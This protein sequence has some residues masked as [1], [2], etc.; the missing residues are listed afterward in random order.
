MM[1]P[2]AAF[3]LENAPY[4][5]FALAWAVHFCTALSYKRA[6]RL[7]RRQTEARTSDE[8]SREAVSV[9]ITAHDQADALRRNLPLILEQEYDRFEVIVVND[10][11][12]DDTEEVLKA[13]ELK[14]AGLRHT[15]APPGTRHA[16]RKRLSLTIGIKAAHYE[17]LLLTGPDCRP[18]SPR[19][20]ATMAGHFRDG[21]QIVLGYAN[22]APDKRLLSRKATFFNLFH[23]MQY[24]PWAAR[25]KAYR[26]NPANVACR[27][28][29]F[30][31]HKGFADDGG[32]VCGETELLVNRLSKAGNTVTSLHPDGKV[33]QDNVES[34]RQWRLGRAS[35][36]EVRRHFRHTWCYRAA[37]NLKQVIVPLS[38]CATAAAAGWSVW[39]RQ[40][41]ATASVSLLFVLLCVCKT[42]W[43]NRSARALRE[44]PY[45]LSFLWYEM[46]LAG[47]HTGSWISYHTAPRARFYRRTS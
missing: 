10:A 18:C 15:F 5:V 44:R 36:M 22:Y 24:L 8:S 37:F 3:L 11:S 6:A 46:C 32:L 26:C 39:L 19:W 12:T 31:R 40:W 30:M 23:Q 17:W 14:Y 29:F 1:R 9:V 45:R 7:V 41:A 34:G 43:F 16:N 33:W 21:T 13:L 4:A 47:W 25:H 28:S 38:Y 35:Y 20:I 42:V 27:K 2:L